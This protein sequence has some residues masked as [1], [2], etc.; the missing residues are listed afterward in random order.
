MPAGGGVATPRQLPHSIAFDPDGKF[1]VADR[2]NN[3]IQIFSPEGDYLGMWTGMSGPDDITRGKDGNF[4]I[5]EQEDG[6]KPAQVWVRDAK[7]TVL[8]RVESRPVHC[9]GVD[10][11]GDIYAGLTTERS[12]DKFVR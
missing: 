10:P 3:R 2:A 11:R 6:D 7:G 9:V 1:Y 8:A 12:A 4:Y 5:A